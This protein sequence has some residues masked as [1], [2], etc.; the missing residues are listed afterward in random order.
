V[1]PVSYCQLGLMPQPPALIGGG[2]GVVLL[3]F[4]TVG[5]NTRWN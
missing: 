3:I 1:T 5:R 2:F 4:A